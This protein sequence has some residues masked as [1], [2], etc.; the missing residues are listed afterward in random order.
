VRSQ[1][2]AV[3]HHPRYRPLAGVIPSDAGDMR[4]FA[5]VSQFVFY[6]RSEHI[7]NGKRK[8]AGDIRSGNMYLNWTSL[9][10]QISHVRYEAVIREVSA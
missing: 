7:S 10:R 1:V 9:K 5:T 8:G 3:A 6:G 2:C 4:R